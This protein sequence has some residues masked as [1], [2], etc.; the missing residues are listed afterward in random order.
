MWG[1]MLRHWV[2]GCLHFVPSFSWVIQSSV[3]LLGLLDS[4]DEGTWNIGSSLP[5]DVA[6]HCRRTKSMVHVVTRL[7]A[8]RSGVQVP[9]RVKDFFFSKMSSPVGPIQPPIEQVLGHEV[10]HSTSSNAN[11]LNEWSYTCTPH[12]SLWCVQ[13]KLCM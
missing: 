6:S 10:N 5:T 4:R 2:S 9:V 7:L 8:G 3:T 12:M 1:A 13:G 11:V